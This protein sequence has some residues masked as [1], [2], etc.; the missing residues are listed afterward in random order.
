LEY[1]SETQLYHA[2][3]RYYKA[4]WGLWMNPDPAGM[5]ASSTGNPQ[6]NN[7]FAYVI[8]NPG[9]F[10]DPTGLR[11]APASAIPA[12]SGECTLGGIFTPCSLVGSIIA[13]GGAAQCPNNACEGSAWVSDSNGGHW[14]QVQFW[15]FANGG[16]GY[17][18]YTGPG[19]LYYSVQGA[20]L[21]AGR[22]MWDPNDTHEYHTNIYR[23]KN[24]VFSYTTPE[25][26]PDCAETLSEGLG[27]GCG[28]TPDLS[29]PPGTDLVGTEH[30]HPEVEGLSSGEFSPE[31]IDE[32]LTAK[33]DAS[34]AFV[35]IF[36]F[37]VTP[38]GDRILMFDPARWRLFNQFGGG[39]TSPVCV[40]AGPLQTLSRC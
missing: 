36:G 25:Q 15:E 8:N 2:S 29:V 39:S 7:R 16:S 6:S 18:A 37:V 12:D 40:L 27:N 20:A 9:N 19:A 14:E 30:T 5:A 3:F 22:Y 31:D 26:G 35:P 21:A 28:W 23:D 32:Y 17:Y 13:G 4:G 33:K 1:D 11:E 34:G 38:P 10:V 24:E